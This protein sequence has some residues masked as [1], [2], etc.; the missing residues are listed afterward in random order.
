MV[1]AKEK[2]VVE[3]KLNTLKEELASLEDQTKIAGFFLISFII[4]Y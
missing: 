4:H 2:R 1:K 3:T